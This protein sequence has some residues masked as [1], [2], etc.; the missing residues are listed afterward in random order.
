ML[1][2]KLLRQ[3]VESGLPGQAYWLVSADMSILVGEVD[4]IKSILGIKKT[5]VI[6]VLP[7]EKKNGEITIGKIKIL[8]SELSKSSTGGRRL[9]VIH[10]ADRMTEEASNSFLKTLEEP[11]KDTSIV[12]L[13]SSQKIIPTIASRCQLFKFPAPTH[14]YR[15][16]N[17]AEIEKLASSSLKELFSL[18]EKISKEGNG[19]LFIADLTHYYY[20]LFKADPR[21][22]SIITYLVLARKHFQANVAE[23]L[24]IENILLLIYSGQKYGTRIKN[25]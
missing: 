15:L 17:V 14:G 16:Y 12:M 9:V 25:N 22:L 21:A 18:A 13:S 11:P 10:Q 8:R 2:K 20:T 3:K 7:E 24:V 23:R 1:A 19:E 6:E 5:E 4:Q